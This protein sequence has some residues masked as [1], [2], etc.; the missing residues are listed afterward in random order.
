MTVVGMRP[1]KL[2]QFGI[3]ISRGNR[4][5]LNVEQSLRFSPEKPDHAVVSMDSD[6][7]TILIFER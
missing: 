7:I 5:M 6:A 1:A 3:H 2:R 4:A